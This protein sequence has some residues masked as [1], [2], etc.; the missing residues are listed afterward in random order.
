MLRND[1]GHIV[2]MLGMGN[3][4][5][6][7]ARGMFSGEAGTL[8]V[9]AVDGV[10]VHA[11]GRMEVA[12]GQRI[13]VVEAGG[14]G[15]GDPRQRSRDAVRADVLDGFVSDDAARRVYGVES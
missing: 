15:F 5:E 14:G 3:R 6:F 8:R 4:T 13:T 10:A 7:P 2:T 9:H 11:K 12:P 1:T